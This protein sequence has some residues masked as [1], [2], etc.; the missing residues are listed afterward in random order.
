MKIKKNP[1]RIKPHE[2]Q[3]KKFFE[4]IRNYK[5]QVTLPTIC[6]DAKDNVISQPDLILERWKDYFCKILNIA[7][8]IDIQTIKRERI[9][10]QPQIPLQSY[11]KICLII[12]NLKLNK[13]TG[14]DNI[15]PELLQHGSR[16]LKQKLYK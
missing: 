16:T 12:N 1:N 11:N 7:K 10:N 3:N 15:H 6:K 4:G 5:Q 8:S 9:N 2:I 14:S 13:A